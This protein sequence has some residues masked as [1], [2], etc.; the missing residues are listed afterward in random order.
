MC[1]R[2]SRVSGSIVWYSSSI[3]ML[4]L[5]RFIVL[6]F[7]GGSRNLHSYPAAGRRLPGEEGAPTI[8]GNLAGVLLGF[9]NRQLGD[10]VHNPVEILLAH[11]VNV[12]VRC[13]VHEVDRVRN[14][15]LAGELDGVQ[16]VAERLAQGDRVPLHPS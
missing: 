8:L 7:R 14:V 1:D 4:R 13:W 10:G 2:R 3:P 15:V 5:G 6:T 9:A 16:V 11:G 12:S